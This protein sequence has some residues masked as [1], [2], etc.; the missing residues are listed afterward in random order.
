MEIRPYH[1]RLFAGQ[2]WYKLDV[3]R[4][5]ISKNYPNVSTSITY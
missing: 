3:Y 4:L 2:I 5:E 1:A